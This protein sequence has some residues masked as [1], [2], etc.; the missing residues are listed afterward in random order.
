MKNIAIALAM[1][2][3]FITPAQAS[4]LFTPDQVQYEAPTYAFTGFG[5]GIDGGGQFNATQI[6]CPDNQKCAGAFF[7]GI[8]SDGLIGGAHAE[9]LF[10]VDRF[11]LGAYVEGGFSNV[12]TDVN[13][14]GGDFDLLQQD[15][16]YGVGL[17]AGVTIFGNTLLYA[18]AGYDW[19]QWT[20]FE[21]EDADVGSLL[22][23]GGI[24][25]MVADHWSLGLGVDY[26]LVNDVEAAGA[27]LSDLFDDSEM[28]RAKMALTR[29]W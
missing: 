19:S 25:A 28:L 24:E 23:G 29:R 16:Y 10:A 27:D 12:N 26:M 3:A 7:D 20:V 6:N 15:S 8:S 2:A 22:F 4:D 18:R 5:V 1:L 21:T 11:R 14:G 13:F 9:Y 17:K